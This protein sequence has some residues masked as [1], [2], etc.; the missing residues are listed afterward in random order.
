VYDVVVKK[1]HVRYLIF[2]WVSCANITET[3]AV[4]G[5]AIFSKVDV[6]LSACRRP[7]SM[8]KVQSL[9]ITASLLQCIASLRNHVVW[10][11]K[12]FDIWDR[13]AV[14]SVTDRQANRRTDLL[15]AHAALHHIAQPEYPTFTFQLNWVIINC[16]LCPIVAWL[17]VALVKSYSCE[18]WWAKLNRDSI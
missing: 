10:C 5:L 3:Y 4:K 2:W 16:S 9:V 17:C 15:I 1:V 8:F 18:Q 6:S 13:L 11:R 14:T 12:Y 7:F